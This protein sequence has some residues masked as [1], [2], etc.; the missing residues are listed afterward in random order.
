MDS[1]PWK[2]KHKHLFFTTATL[3]QVRAKVVE[4]KKSLRLAEKKLREARESL[5]GGP[6][7]R[8][9]KAFGFRLR[10]QVNRWYI[11]S[12][13]KLLRTASLARYGGDSKFLRSDISRNN[14]NR[15]SWDKC[16]LTPGITV[17][18]SEPVRNPKEDKNS[19]SSQARDVSKHNDTKCAL[20]GTPI[21]QLTS[22][23]FSSRNK[24]TELQPRYK[25][26]RAKIFD[27]D[28]KMAKL[29]TRVQTSANSIRGLQERMGTI[30]DRVKGLELNV[31][32]RQQR[33][34]RICCLEKLLHSATQRAVKAE[35]REGELETRVLELEDSLEVYDMKIHRAQNLLYRMSED[36]IPAEDSCT[37]VTM[38]FR[39]ASLTR[40]S[41]SAS[42]KGHGPLIL[43]SCGEESDS[44]VGL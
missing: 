41:S 6:E 12:D 16:P 32:H 28:A 44:S 30:A 14:D 31:H 23:D 9:K 13:D 5:I 33:E 8:L 1:N 19:S 11:V 15:R 7:E 21:Q 10:S 37:S 43:D 38:V 40:Q 26:I 20:L 27:L 3:E 34:S 35:T 25:T 4:L 39:R 2:A 42:F 17:S 29:K 36:D 18:H 22:K 24:T